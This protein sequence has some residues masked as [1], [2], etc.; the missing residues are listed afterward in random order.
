MVIALDTRLVIASL[1]SQGMK[2]RVI[3]RK[4][5]TQNTLMPA[6]LYRL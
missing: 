6:S 3:A 2:L 5:V 1:I 4:F